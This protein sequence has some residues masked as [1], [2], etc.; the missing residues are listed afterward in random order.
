MSTCV[1][2]FFDLKYDFWRS[3]NPITGYCEHSKRHYSL[4]P[5]F[6]CSSSIAIAV[7]IPFFISFSFLVYYWFYLTDICS[8]NQSTCIIFVAEQILLSENFIL[9]SVAVSFSRLQTIELNKW[10]SLIE[11]IKTYK[12]DLN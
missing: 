10:C 6:K 11:K 7:I 1:V 5:C 8:R 9:V 12:I 3:L 2:C 4:K